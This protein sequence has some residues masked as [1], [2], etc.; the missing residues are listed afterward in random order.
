MR[1]KIILPYSKEHKETKYSI[2]KESKKRIELRFEN[3]IGYFEISIV[4][5]IEDRRI[6]DLIKL[7]DASFTLVSIGRQSWKHRYLVFE[8]EIDSD[9]EE[10]ENYDSIIENLCCEGTSISDN[11]F[12]SREMDYGHIAEYCFNIYMIA[13]KMVHYHYY[14]FGRGYIIVNDKFYDRTNKINNVCL[15]DINGEI[16]YEFE[17][18]DTEVIWEYIFYSKLL[19]DDH[20]TN[21]ISR[22][23][24]ALTLLQN[25]DEMMPLNNLMIVMMALESLYARGTESIS[26]QLQEKIKLFLGERYIEKKK[27]TSLYGIRS[28]YIHGDI[29]LSFPFVETDYYFEKVI[30]LRDTF[31]YAYFLLVSTLIKIINENRLTFNFIN[32]LE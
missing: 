4:D 6:C 2:N 25:D 11:K 12:T 21:N 10:S 20:S 3:I 31:E 1:I 29:D 30:E 7:D 9:D 15:E 26:A 17:E 18:I 8:F 28:R 19:K 13:L 32:K 24:V 27:I 14:R 23:I 16:K 22:A 5:E